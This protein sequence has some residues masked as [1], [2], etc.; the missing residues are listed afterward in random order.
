MGYME[1]SIGEV[2]GLEGE[3]YG[4]MVEIPVL[5]PRQQAKKH[6]AL[7]RFR[8]ENITFRV[9]AGRK[10]NAYM[11]DDRREGHTWKFVSN[12]VVTDPSAPNN[13]R[14]LENGILYC[15]QLNAN[16]TGT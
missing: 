5:R 3:K 14:L 9:E 6:T 8:H 12:G 11:G 2:F 10:L 13:S 4:W 1:D 16:G 15:A 7:G